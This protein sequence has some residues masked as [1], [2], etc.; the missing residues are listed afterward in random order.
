LRNA[1]HIASCAFDSTV[2]RGSFGPIGASCTYARRFY[3][4]TVFGLMS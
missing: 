3:F 1:T 2:E 4:A